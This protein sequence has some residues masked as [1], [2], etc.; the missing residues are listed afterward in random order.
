MKKNPFLQRE[1][2]FSDNELLFEKHKFAISC[3][4]LLK[5][6]FVEQKNK[7]SVISHGRRIYMFLP[8]KDSND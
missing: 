3:E 5:L 8:K 1:E 4:F 2:F 7:L 6:E